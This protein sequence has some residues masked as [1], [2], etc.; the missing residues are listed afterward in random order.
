[1][2]LDEALA[3]GFNPLNH[4]VRACGG[5]GSDIFCTPH[6]GGINWR[7][8]LAALEK[9]RLLGKP[10]KRLAARQFLIIFRT[11]EAKTGW[12]GLVCPALNFSQLVTD[13]R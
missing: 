9:Y 13:T 2:F 8:Y 12:R 5:A 7:Y 11:V 4:V 1:L 6:D 10:A 3:L